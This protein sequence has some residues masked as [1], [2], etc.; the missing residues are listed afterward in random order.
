MTDKRLFTVSI[1]A[2]VV[3]LAESQEQAEEI[4]Q[5]AA[6]TIDGDQWEA[7]PASPMTCMPG[8]WDG[9]CIP[10]GD[11]DPQEPDRTIAQWIERG[12][13]PAYTE[14]FSKLKAATA[15]HGK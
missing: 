7:S 9:E 8:G 1:E 15:K 3:V 13:A 2:E 11:G 12:A 14:L 5:K 4:A 10:F 6:G